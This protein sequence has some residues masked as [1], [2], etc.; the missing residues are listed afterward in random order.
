MAGKTKVSLARLLDFIRDEKSYR[1]VRKAI[2]KSGAADLD[3]ILQHVDKAAD[4][5][6]INTDIAE[7]EEK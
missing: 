1:D 5:K 6:G 2:Q 7:R 3:R 4:L